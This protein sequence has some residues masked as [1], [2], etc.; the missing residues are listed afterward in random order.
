MRFDV[1]E[2]FQVRGIY[3]QVQRDQAD[4]SL[5]GD[6]REILIPADL[7]LLAI[8]FEGVTSQLTQ[9]LNLKV[10][11]QKIM[12]DTSDYKTN[13]PKYFAAGDARRGQSLVVWAIKEGREVAASVHSHLSAKTFV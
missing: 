9:A 12:A 4:G 6:D 5:V 2:M 1:D 11:R 7:V 8:G 13:Q 3:A 10:N